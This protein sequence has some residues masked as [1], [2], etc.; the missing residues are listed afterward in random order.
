MVNFVSFKAALINT[1]LLTVG[2][3]SSV[4]PRA[5]A[6]C[7]SASVLEYTPVHKRVGL[8]HITLVGA[9]THGELKRRTFKQK[10]HK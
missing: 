4:I 1:F 6:L 9:R 3:I 7:F 8:M 10:F 2:Q 5:I